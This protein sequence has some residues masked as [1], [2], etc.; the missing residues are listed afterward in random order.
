M[1]WESEMRTPEAEIVYELLRPG[2][3]GYFWDQLAAVALTDPSVVTF[4]WHYIAV[5]VD[6]GNET[7]WTQSLDQDPPNTI[8]AVHA[9]AQLFED[10]FIAV[11]NYLEPDL[12][13]PVLIVVAVA[14]GI[15]IVLCIIVI[16]HFRRMEL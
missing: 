16:V 6:G 13:P 10:T 12:A 15:V 3:G 2:M 11:L 5:L 8:V 9:D 4:E 1:R 14:F 7:G